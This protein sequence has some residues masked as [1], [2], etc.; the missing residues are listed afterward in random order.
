MIV[1]RAHDVHVAVETPAKSEVR[2]SL[3]C[4]RWKCRLGVGKR[5]AATECDVALRELKTSL[6][7]SLQVP[8]PS[9]KEQPSFEN[10]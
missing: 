3:P 6:G 2:R 9:S 10:S 4:R 5:V 8:S 1:T 7:G